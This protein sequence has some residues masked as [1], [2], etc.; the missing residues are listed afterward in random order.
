MPSYEV[1]YRASVNLYFVVEANS[2]EEADKQIK[3]DMLEE[4]L[5]GKVEND[6]LSIDYDREGIEE[7]D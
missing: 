2:E 7:L 5:K 4:E 6:K 3:F 1:C